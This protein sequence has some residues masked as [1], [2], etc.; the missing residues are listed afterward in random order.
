[1]FIGGF[2]FAAFV[3]WVLSHYF[4]QFDAMGWMIVGAIVSIFGTI[5]DLVESMIKRSVG[6][7]DSGSFMPGHGGF[8]DRF[9]AFIFCIPFVFGFY[10]ITLLMK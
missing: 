3:G 8:L 6:V 5:G 7:K 4:T 10:M 9:D 2:I 1:G